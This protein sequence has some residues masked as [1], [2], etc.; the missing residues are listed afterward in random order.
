[1]KCP[2]CGHNDSR[3]IDSRETETKT[4]GSIRRRRECTRC[5]RR[6]TT[7]ERMEHVGLSVVKKSGQREDYDRE[8]LRRGVATACHR[9]PV[10]TDAADNVVDDVEAELFRQGSAE[11]SSA[12]IGELVMTRLRGLN[13]IAYLR[14]AS[15]YLSF[16]TMRDLQDAIDR[17]SLDAPTHG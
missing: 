16:T 3:V 5:A 8:K 6:Y 10:P 14:F 17:V 7:Y 9:L 4:G 13:P 12:L 15:V 2:Y 1:M 11:V